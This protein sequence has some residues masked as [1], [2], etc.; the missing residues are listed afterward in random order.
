MNH[1]DARPAEP[2]MARKS[3][4]HNPSDFEWAR[5]EDARWK[6][7][8]EPEISAVVSWRL[9]DAMVGSGCPV[10]HE[11]LDNGVA[12]ADWAG[13]KDLRPPLGPGCSCC[14]IGIT[15]ARAMRLIAEGKA[16]DL[17]KG[18]PDGAGPDHGWVRP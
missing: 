15:R 9:F 3:E 5:K 16:F 10:N 7:L 2:Q 4:V 18:L 12:P 11:V 13:W 17:T 8:E 14:T 1:A 6:E